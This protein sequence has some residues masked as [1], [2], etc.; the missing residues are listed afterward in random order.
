MNQELISLVKYYNRNENQLFADAMLQWAMLSGFRDV[1]EKNDVISFNDR[2]FSTKSAENSL[3]IPPDWDT[4]FAKRQNQFLTKIMEMRK[5]KAKKNT[6]NYNR[7]IAGTFNRKKAIEND[8][9]HF[10]APGDDI[11]DCIVDN[12]IRSCRGQSAAFAMKA[13]FNWVGFVYTWS[14][15]PNERLLIE[16]DIPLSY[17][18]SFRNYLAVEQVQIPV[19]IKAEEEISD[20][21]VIRAFNDIL[22]RDIESSKDDIEHLGKRGKQEGFLN[23]YTQYKASNIDYFKSL[24][25][26]DRWED[27]VSKS[28]RISKDKALKILR[29][30]SH[31]SDARIEVE[32]ILTSIIATAKYYGQESD[33]YDRLKHIYEIVIESLSKPAV[34]LES[35][36]FVWM[37]KK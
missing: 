17:L 10:F 31:V 23:I 3:L 26:P 25:S 8:Y 16:N 22:Q 1:E 18:S 37:V 36:C 28:R 4:Y 29:S 21:R 24:Y 33:N 5:E 19:R 32:R 35:A 13:D 30:R 27:M 34:R 15:Y 2:S 14:L 11:F 20:D 12:A 6:S 9:I 7:A